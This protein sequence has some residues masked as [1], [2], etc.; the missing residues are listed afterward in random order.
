ME[1]PTNRSLAYLLAKSIQKDDLETVTGGTMIGVTSRQTVQL[2][3]DS[4]QGPS[5]HYDISLDM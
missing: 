5:I 3:G 1:N 2:G 4:A